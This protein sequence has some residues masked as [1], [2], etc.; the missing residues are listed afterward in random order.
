MHENEARLPCLG[1][2]TPFPASAIEDVT[3]RVLRTKQGAGISSMHA[4]RI[5]ILIVCMTKCPWRCLHLTSSAHQVDC[6]PFHCSIIKFQASHKSVRD[7]DVTIL[8][9]V[10][11]RNRANA[12]Q[13]FSLLTP[14]LYRP[15]VMLTCS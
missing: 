12:K 6:D 9:H 10:A 4:S 1:R 8:F 11:F 2:S 14:L 13:A 15:A 5:S 3:V 7:G